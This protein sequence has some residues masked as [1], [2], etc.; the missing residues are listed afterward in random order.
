MRDLRNLNQSELADITGLQAS[1]ISQFENGARKP[2][3]DNL[4]RL[5]DALK[6]TTD[7][8]LGRVNDPAGLTGA[9]EIYRNLEKLTDSDRIFA[10][11]LI[12]N[13]ANIASKG[14][15]KGLNE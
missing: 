15:K 5:A 1:A 14:D 11:K 6:V 4:K 9:E 3:F 8:L 2:S 7:Y 12:E 13:L 10:E